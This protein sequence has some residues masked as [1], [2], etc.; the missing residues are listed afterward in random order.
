MFACKSAVIVLL[1]V[2]LALVQGQKSSSR[3][4]NVDVDAV[5]SN[6]RLLKNYVDCLLG[7]RVCT[8]EGAEVKRSV[9]YNIVKQKIKY[10]T[11]QD[12]YLN[13]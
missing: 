11:F 4:D 5:L 12:F 10:F 1:C 13:P 3:F 8:P 6:K 7:T 2:V 9:H